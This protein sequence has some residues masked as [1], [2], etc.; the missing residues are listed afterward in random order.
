[1]SALE[2]G[3][4]DGNAVGAKGDVYVRDYESRWPVGVGGHGASGAWLLTEPP[5]KNTKGPLGCHIDNGVS[6]AVKAVGTSSVQPTGI[7]II[8]STKYGL[9]YPEMKVPRALATFAELDPPAFDEPLDLG[10]GSIW[11]ANVSRL[12]RAGPV[13]PAAPPRLLP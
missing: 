7:A 5:G 2:L 1:V 11:L 4:N 12:G 6:K 8:H 3:A 10:V 13:R 9:R